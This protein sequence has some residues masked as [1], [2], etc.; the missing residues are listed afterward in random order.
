MQT[1]WSQD[2]ASSTGEDNPLCESLDTD[3]W[4]PHKVEGDMHWVVL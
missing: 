1:I 4:S 2:L 3:L